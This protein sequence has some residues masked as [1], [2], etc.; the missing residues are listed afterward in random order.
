LT[1][2]EYSAKT[3]G[4]ASP[5]RISFV[6]LRNGGGKM[7]RPNKRR[8]V[9]AEDHLAERIAMERD[10]RGWTNDGLARRMTDVGCAM[11]PSA[12][13]KIEKAN[14]RRRI[15]VDELVAFGRV[16]GVPIDELLVAPELL[17]SREA[18]RLAIAW[19][20]A[21][22][23]AA[24]ASEKEDA[25]WVDVQTFA[26]E[27]PEAGRDFEGIFKAWAQF[28][29]DE[30]HREN[31]AALLMYKATGADQW[32]DAVVADL[33]AFIDERGANGQHQEA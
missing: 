18:T 28:Y 4:K 25:A 1:Y 20:Y 11:T 19:N 12:I 2:K 17:L 24:R 16:F 13:F 7:P 9:L 26:R 6:P 8:Q 3:V 22:E 14:P 15:V 23:E 27:H 33:Q 5:M 30:D 10:A 29:V 31:A 21:A 32:R